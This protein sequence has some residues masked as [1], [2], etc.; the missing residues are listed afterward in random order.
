MNHKIPFNILHTKPL[1]HRILATF[2]LFTRLSP[3]K[4]GYFETQITNEGIFISRFLRK[5]MLLPWTEIS[6]LDLA[7]LLKPDLSWLKK[8]HFLTRFFLRDMAKTRFFLIMSSNQKLLRSCF[9][10]KKTWLAGSNVLGITGISLNSAQE[11]F[12]ILSEIAREKQINLDLI[13]LS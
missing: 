3:S 5:P 2:L 6:C 8:T 1:I 11:L 13:I 9:A 10:G 4:L 12:S 7:G